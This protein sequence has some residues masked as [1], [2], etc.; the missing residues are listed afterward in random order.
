MN[1][2]TTP[3]NTLL[4]ANGHLLKHNAIGGIEDRQACALI[5]CAVDLL[6][7]GGREYGVEIGRI[8]VPPTAETQTLR[9]QIKPAAPGTVFERSRTQSCT[10]SV[11]AVVAGERQIF[12]AQ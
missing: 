10:V 12:S 6:E 1:T 2:I 8:V 11:D 7:F 5:D 4:N 9:I 3:Y